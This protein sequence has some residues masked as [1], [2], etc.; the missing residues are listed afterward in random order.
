[1]SS[2]HWVSTAK[3]I[4]L[5][6]IVFQFDLD[7]TLSMGGDAAGSV[8]ISRS[9]LKDIPSRSPNKKRNINITFIGVI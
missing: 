3:F 7:G 1:M 2:R 4:A 8:Y 9:L 6:T 5:L